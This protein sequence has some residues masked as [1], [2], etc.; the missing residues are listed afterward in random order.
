MGD[1][2]KVILLQEVLKVIRRD[3]L[4]QNATVTGDILYKV[5]RSHA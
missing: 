4:L 2:G 5:N 1:P 3:N